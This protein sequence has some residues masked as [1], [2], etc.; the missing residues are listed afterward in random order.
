[1]REFMNIIENADHCDSG[2]LT[3]INNIDKFSDELNATRALIN[4][5]EWVKKSKAVG[6]IGPLSLR[7]YHS[8]EHGGSL[9]F[10]MD[11]KS[12]IGKATVVDTPNGYLKV[13]HIWFQPAYRGKGYGFAF[14][15]YLL[16][17]GKKVLS[18]Y[19]QTEYSRRIW[20][21]LAKEFVVRPVVDGQVGEPTKDVSEY[22][23]NSW[24]LLLASLT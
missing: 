10:L 16:K 13:S 4:W 18:D 3:E 11:G 2:A 19:D 21:K 14:Y 12:P 8:K 1:M 24:D 22:Y 7:V 23:G 17:R 9:Y 20:E 5:D 15:V 6:N